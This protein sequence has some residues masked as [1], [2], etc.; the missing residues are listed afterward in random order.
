MQSLVVPRFKELSVKQIWE[1]V[2]NIS[3]YAQYFPDFEGSK[4]PERDYL[5]AIISTLDPEATKMIVQ[6]ALDKR[7]IMES[8]NDGDLV[9]IT[10]ELS[11]EIQKLKLKE[12][13]QISLIM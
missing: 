6:Q 11:S 8:P 1:L 10:K 7:S 3:N 2:K 13:K 5:I 12:S 9:K 4:L